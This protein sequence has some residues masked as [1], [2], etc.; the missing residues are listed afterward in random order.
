M[1]CLDGERNGPPE[2]V[3]GPYTYPEFLDAL[4]DP[5]HED[6]EFYVDWLGD[7]F[8]PKAFNVAEVNERLEDIIRG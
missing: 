6:H 8:D 7:K 1:S 5:D 4:A 2:D 3:G